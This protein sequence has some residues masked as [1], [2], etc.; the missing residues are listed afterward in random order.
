VEAERMTIQSIFDQVERLKAGLGNVS[1]AELSGDG[2]ATGPAAGRHPRAQE[3]I[4][5][6]TI[7]PVHVPRG[8]LEFWADPASP[9]HR[10]YFQ[11]NRRTVVCAG[12]GH[13]A[14]LPDRC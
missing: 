13:S 10:D 7:P 1:V 4:D 5:L 8:M 11:E 9:Y 6:G 3:T 12:G 2:R 14:S